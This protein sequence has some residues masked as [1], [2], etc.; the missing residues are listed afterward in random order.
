[1]P[2]GRAKGGINIFTIFPLTIFPF[3]IYMFFILFSGN[4]GDTGLPG[5]QRTLDGTL[6]T[7]PMLSGVGW[8]FRLGDLILFIGLITLSIE[9]IKATSAKTSSMINHAGSMAVFVLALIGF[10]VF[11]SFATSVFFFLMLMTL[12]DVVAGSMITIVSARRDFGVGDGIG[13]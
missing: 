9:L 2:R 8:R 3:L 5:V 7:V 11:S 12:V 1:M 13:Q 4:G 10:F 6:F